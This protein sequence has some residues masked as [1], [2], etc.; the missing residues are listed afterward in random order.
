MYTDFQ[1]T[2]YHTRPIPM[3][4]S[5]QQEKTSFTC[6]STLAIHLTSSSH[7]HLHKYGPRSQAEC[8]SDRPGHIAETRLTTVILYIS[9]ICRCDIMPNYNLSSSSCTPPRGSWEKRHRPLRREL[10]PPC[11]LWQWRI[12]ITISEEVNEYRDSCHKGCSRRP[13]VLSSECE[14]TADDVCSGRPCR[15]HQCFYITGTPMYDHP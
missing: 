14:N 4:P 9:T 7:M 6:N 5:V 11:E 2:V 15:F 10:S 1:A 13:A 8:L 12:G 3:P